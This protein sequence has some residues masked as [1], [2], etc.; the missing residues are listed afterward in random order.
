MA[1]RQIERRIYGQYFTPEPVVSACFGLLA[2]RLPAN[3]QLVDPACGDGVFLRFAVAHA[4]AAPDHV[5][6]CDVDPLLVRQTVAAGLGK[7]THGDGLA[8]EALPAGA[9][10]L[11]IGNPPFGV[12]TTPGSGALASE[13]RFLLRALELVRRGGYIAL[14][15]PSGVLANR[16]LRELRAAILAKT[17][18]VAA[19]SLPRETFRATGTDAACTIT[20]L[21]AEPAPPDHHTY[22]AIAATLAEMPLI[23]A[24]FHQGRQANISHPECFWLPQSATFAERMDAHYWRPAYRELLAGLRARHDVAPLGEIIG[25]DGLIAGD[26]VRPKLGERKG[27]GF[28]YQYYQTREFLPA[29]Y[30]YARIEHCDERAYHRLSYTGVRRH[31]VLVSCAGIGGAGR[32]RVCLIGH[33]P[34]ASCTGDVFILRTERINPVVLFLFLSARAGRDQLLRLQNGVGTVNLSADELL[35]VLVPLLPPAEMQRLAAEFTPAAVA[36]DTS[37]AALLRG[38]AAGFAREQHCASVFLG[39]A[40]QAVLAAVL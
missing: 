23:V 1:E 13:V 31:D 29:G 37:M 6:G 28:A 21:R 4:L 20:V 22:F 24:R 25:R 2:G 38:D 39:N 18:L 15:L 27:A 36:H 32:A 19:I 3:P 34:G 10:D 33:Q 12:A 7:V 35:D 40:Q 26:H 11:V 5:H 8:T 16:R 17:T 30:D 14:I 9:F